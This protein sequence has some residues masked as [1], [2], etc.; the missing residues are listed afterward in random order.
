MMRS[1]LNIILLMGLFFTVH[2]AKY[3]SSTELST[4]K[5]LRGIKSAGIIIRLSESSRIPRTEFQQNLSQ[6]LNSA[7]QMRKL[8]LVE[9]CSDSIS[10]YSESNRFYQ[11]SGEN[12]AFLVFKSRGII[13]LYLQ[14]NETELKKIMAENTLD[15][16]IIYEVYPV[17]SFE[18]QFMDF[19][20]AIC[21]V[22]RNL[23]TV[24]LDHQS[25]RYETDEISVDKMKKN[26]LDK[27][28]DRFLGKIKELGLIRM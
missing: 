12:G 26:L 22:D 6:W 11:L 17:I 9:N 7:K 3:T 4:G 16:L 5:A 8:I 19:D 2:C 13:N 21:I 27:T 23:N 25:N 14:K 10:M 28:S 15:G 18:M 1:I 24:F 20:S